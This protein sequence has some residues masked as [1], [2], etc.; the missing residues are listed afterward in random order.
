MK[1]A[2]KL[3]QDLLSRSLN[4]E[5]IH[6]VGREVD[7][8]FDLAEVSGFGDHIVIPR[9]VAAQC[10]IQY[11]SARE[12]LLDFIARLVMLEGYGGSG[13]I[14]KLKGIEPI[15]NELR[16]AGF[17]LDR[18]KS[19]FVRDQAQSKTQDWGFL[20][21]GQEY[22]LA[23][24]SL[25]IVGSSELIRTNVK[26]DVENTIRSLRDFVGSHVEHYNGRI[27]FWYGDGGM[28]AFI[29]DESVRSAAMACLGILAYLPA[30]NITR[31]AL[32]EENDI[33]LRIG[34]HYGSVVYQSDPSKMHSEDMERAS[35]LE[36]RYGVPNAIIVSETAFNLLPDELRKYFQSSGSADFGA[37]YQNLVI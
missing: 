15:L 21:D 4:T 1:K 22:R 7:P 30:Y 19:A 32:R 17:V 28:A 34:I 8:S 33:R 24:A 18:E 14:I 5:Q 26:V 29:G 16:E 12:K 6:Y 23:F 27:W 20:R 2:K 31:N 25:D 9:Q 35:R 36:D 3:L 37:L 11:F 13:G 10:V